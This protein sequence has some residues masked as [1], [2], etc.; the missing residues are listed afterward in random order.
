VAITYGVKLTDAQ[1]NASATVDG[2][3]VAGTFRYT[4]AV[5]TLLDAGSAQVLK[6]TFTP[7]DTANYA[8]VTAQA[9]ID[10]AKAPLTITAEDEA[11]VAGGIV[12][13]LTARYSGF[14]NGEDAG[15]LDTPVTVTT[16]ASSAS[17]PG[18]YSILSA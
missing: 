5:G 10:V 8:S 1:C 2:Q 18:R 9:G 6:V 15:A 11:M 13:A 4:P 7:A 16:S 14:V 17:M 3:F 12:P